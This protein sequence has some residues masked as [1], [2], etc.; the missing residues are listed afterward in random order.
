MSKIVSRSLKSQSIF[1]AGALVVAAGLFSAQS[2]AVEGGAAKAHAHKVASRQTEKIKTGSGFVR[3]TT[4]TDQAGLTAQRTA[5]V[6]RDKEL[7]TRTRTVTGTN[8][9]GGNYSGESVAHKTDAG[10]SA[11]GHLTK[12]DGTTTA[13]DV[14]AVVD[15][16]AGTVTKT[17]S[18]T[19]EGGETT[20]TT[21]VVP[22][23][24]RK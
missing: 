8:F 4:K 15:K 3:K 2:Y 12:A 19:P 6:V 24:H 11:Q 5:T 7:G 23:L 9:E 13:R 10:Y 20:T 17:I 21:K 1:L 16:A 18:V 22:I 14:N